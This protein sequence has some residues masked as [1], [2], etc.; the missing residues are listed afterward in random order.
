MTRVTTASAWAAALAATCLA[1]A[2]GPVSAQSLWIPRDR[3]HAVMLEFLRPSIESFDGDALSGAAFLSARISVSP[4]AAVVAQVPF[5]REDGRER[6]FDYDYYYYL[7]YP[8]YYLQSPSSTIGN[9]Y[10]GVESRPQATPIF[11]ELGFRLPLTSEKETGAQVIGSYADLAR[12]DAFLPRNV[13][14]QAAFNV[15]EVVS[16]GMEY[17]LRLSPVLEIPTENRDETNAFVLH[18]WQIGYHGS[19]VRF[20]TAFSGRTRLNN[21]GNLGTRSMNQLEVHAD[22]LSGSVHPGLDLHVPLG[23]VA[24]TVPVVLGASVSWSR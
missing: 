18:S 7:Y 14:V 13:G 17:R 12:A 15:G 2:A 9:V 21:G 4:L 23:S 22:F 5:A 11:W 16:S 10:I 1:A 3:D 19:I 6:Y 8:W 20:G 24:N